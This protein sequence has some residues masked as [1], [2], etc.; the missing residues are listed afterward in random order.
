MSV[1]KEKVAEES[2]V[3]EVTKVESEVKQNDEPYTPTQNSMPRQ[4]SVEERYVE[5]QDEITNA[6]NRYL[7]NDSAIL[8]NCFMSQI[9]QEVSRIAEDQIKQIHLNS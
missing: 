3:E 4:K 8:I 6:I 2:K 7:A 5:F 9:A 1:K